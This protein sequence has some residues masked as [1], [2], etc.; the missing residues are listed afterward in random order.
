MRL[1]KHIGIIPDG[2]RRWAKGQGMDKSEGYVHGISPGMSLYRMCRELGIG[3]MS[4]YGFTADNTKRRSVQRQAFTRAC[5]AAGE[6]LAKEDAS[7]LVLGNTK[8]PM[9]PHELLPFT[10][11]HDFG[12]GRPR[13]RAGRPSVRLRVLPAR[14]CAESTIP[15]RRGRTRQIGRAHV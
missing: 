3:E 8:S 7:L 2:N 13:V 12:K 1:P 5:E 6:E 11:R 10:A 4:F 9:F 14:R 15:A